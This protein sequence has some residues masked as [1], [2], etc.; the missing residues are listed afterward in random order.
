MPHLHQG[1]DDPF[2]F[3]VGLWPD[4]AGELLCYMVLYAGN[5]EGMT[6]IAPVFHP[7]VGISTFNG[8]R[9]AVNHVAQQKL[10]GTGCGTVRQNGLI[11]F[12]GTVVNRNKQ[13]ISRVACF[14]VLQ[15]GQAF[16]IEMHHFA[17]IGFVVVLGFFELLFYFPFGF[18]QKLYALFGLLKAVV[19]VFCGTGNCTCAAF[20]M[21]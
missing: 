19:G 1:G 11:P 10:G 17:G 3:A 15:Q 5:S 21:R 7:V 6:R 14:L 2:G 12:A 13:V 16:G 18:G 8:I 9:R 4:C 20:R